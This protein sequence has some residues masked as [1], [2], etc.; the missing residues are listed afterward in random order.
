[1][2]LFRIVYVPFYMVRTSFESYAYSLRCPLKCF[3]L[4]HPPLSQSCRNTFNALVTRVC[5]GEPM[6]GL[7]SSIPH[8]GEHNVSLLQGMLAY[9]PDI[10]LSAKLALKH[11]YFADINTTDRRLSPVRSVLRVHV[12]CEF[13]NHVVVDA[14][15]QSHSFAVIFALCMCIQGPKP[16]QNKLCGRS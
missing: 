8:A 13:V 6:L 4:L 2:L 3:I 5:H 12:V 9:D 15:I 10:R 11:E 1:M 7:L 14:P 16:V